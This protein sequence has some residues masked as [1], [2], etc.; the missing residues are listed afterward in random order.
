MGNPVATLPPPV[1]VTDSDGLDP[2]AILNDMIASFQQASGRTLYPAQVERLLINLYA[3]REALARNAIQFAGQSNLL[4]FAV[5]P[6]LDYIGQSVGTPRLGA[7]G[8]TTTLEFTLTTAQTQS[9]T[10]A[11]GTQVGTQD[12]QYVF[13]TSADLTFAAGVTT[14]TVAATCTAVGVGGNGYISGQVSVLIAANALISSVTNT[15]TTANGSPAEEDD[16]YRERIQLA[17]NQFSTAGP[18]GAYEYFARSASTAV[19]D[20]QVS[21]PSPGSVSVVVLAG[22]ITVQPAA[23]PNS[24][25]IANGGLLSTVT[26]A[27]SAKTV[28]PL[29]DTVT[30]SAVTEVDYTITAVVTLYADADQESTQA[31]ANTAAVDLALDLASEIERNLVPSQWVTALSVSGVYEVTVT[32]AANIGGTPISN[33]EDG[34]VLLTSG[35]WANCTAIN[36]SFPVGSEDS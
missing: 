7:V 14:G 3:Y 16:A 32:I 28:R 33:Q 35:Q 22:P 29:C 18:S 5:Y 26:A 11:A 27:L 4:A 20:A 17:P 19:I 21:T 10:I 31:A 2:N 9:Y 34:S 36:L 6:L 23:S 12:G 25:G 13:T 1:F 30:V 24:T 8:A 15:E